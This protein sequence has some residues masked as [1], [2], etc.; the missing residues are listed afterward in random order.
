MTIASPTDVQL[1]R[2]LRQKFDPKS[3]S[4]G[5]AYFREGHVL[6][7]ETEQLGET[8]LI[9]GQVQGTPRR[10]YIT[11]LAM[12]HDDNRFVLLDE[13]CSCPLGGS[14]KHAVA[15]LL[16]VI[17]R[18]QALP[19]STARAPPPTQWDQWFRAAQPPTAAIASAAVE[20][21]LAFIFDIDRPAPLPTLSVRPIWL[22]RLKNGGWGKPEPLKINGFGAATQLHNLDDR[23]HA[24]VSAL[25]MQPTLFANGAEAHRLDGPRGEGLL[26]SLLDQLWCCWQNPRAGELARGQT[27]P[28][29]W[30]WQLQ[31]DGS[32]QLRADG[33]DGL[34]LLRAGGL[35]YFDPQQRH[36][37]R[38]E[39]DAELAQRLLQLPALIPEHIEHVTAHWQRQP[40]LAALPPPLALAP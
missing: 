2:L 4:R 6:K 19:A 5:T 25:R 35:W 3:I 24:L 9:T 13:S 20:Q 16:T 36:L 18:L 11:L 14:C 27:L 26:E 10:P 34:M 7:A 39:H 38:V 40:P 30:Q 17:D 37:G 12:A 21:R 1:T 31:A 23:Q 8:L 22:S 28:L 15:L 32:Q 29:H 33:M